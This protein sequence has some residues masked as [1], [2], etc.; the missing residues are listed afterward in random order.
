MKW[1]KRSPAIT[2]LCRA[3]ESFWEG[4]QILWA[5]ARYVLEPLVG[6]DHRGPRRVDH[7][8]YGETSAASSCSLMLGINRR[9]PVSGSR[10]P[11]CCG[12]GHRGEMGRGLKRPWTHSAPCKHT[13]LEARLSPAWIW[14]SELWRYPLA[15]IRAK[16]S[17]ANKAAKS[18][19]AF[20]AGSALSPAR[21]IERNI[22][23]DSV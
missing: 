14:S 12:L 18:L 15:S 11:R 19:E 4:Y 16:V 2:P 21:E 22:R 1:N 17:L 3:F 20:G 8:T 10:R 5:G 13:R 23:Q 6:E 9:R 7:V